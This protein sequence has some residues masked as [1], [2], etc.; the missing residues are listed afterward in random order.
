MKDTKYVVFLIQNGTNKL[1]D[2][3]L[4]KNEKELFNAINET[5]FEK[6]NCS[7]A[8]FKE[9]DVIEILSK[10]IKYL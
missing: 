8:T 6:L 1:I 3:K 7:Y 4:C 10:T 5:D 2:T 9:M